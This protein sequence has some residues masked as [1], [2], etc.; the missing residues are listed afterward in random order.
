MVRKSISVSKTLNEI[1]TTHSEPNIHKAKGNLLCLSKPLT[2]VPI[3][4]NKSFIGTIHWS[5]RFLVD[6]SFSFFIFCMCNETCYYNYT[7]PLI[8]NETMSNL[9]S[10]F[11]CAILIFFCPTAKCKKLSVLVSPFSNTTCSKKNE[12]KISLNF[13][14]IAFWIWNIFN[15]IDHLSTIH[16]CYSCYITPYIVNCANLQLSCTEKNSSA[17]YSIVNISC[18]K[19]VALSIYFEHFYTTPAWVRTSLQNW[20]IIQVMNFASFFSFYLLIKIVYSTFSC[21]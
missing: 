18:H 16:I 21:T 11:F 2:D 19:Q 13:Y 4:F 10:F 9:K 7:S 6:V 1:M 20:I 17:I 15:L 12:D 5:H 8:S 14:L 3:S